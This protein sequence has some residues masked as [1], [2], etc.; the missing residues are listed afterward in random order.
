V[1]AGGVV[2]EIGRHEAEVD[3]VEPLAL[4]AV[5]ER[6]HE[7]HARRAHVAAHQHPLGTTGLAGGEPSERGADRAG[8]VGVELVGGDATDVVGLEDRVEVGNGW[9]P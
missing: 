9:S 7:V 2:H 3:D 1:L 8:R 4:D 6:G 5:G